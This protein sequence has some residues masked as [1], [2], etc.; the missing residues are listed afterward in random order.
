MIFYIISNRWRISELKT[1]W[2]SWVGRKGSTFLSAAF[3]LNPG[4]EAPGSVSYLT[5][6]EMLRRRNRLTSSCYRVYDLWIEQ[7][8]MEKLMQKKPKE[9]NHFLFKKNIGNLHFDTFSCW[10]S[11]CKAAISPEASSLMTAWANHTHIK[12]TWITYIGNERNLRQNLSNI[13]VNKQAL[14]QMI[15]RRESEDVQEHTLLRMNFARWANFSVLKVSAALLWTNTDGEHTI[16]KNTKIKM[17]QQICSVICAQSL[18]SGK[19]GVLGNG[20]WNY[21]FEGLTVAITVVLELPPR[22]SC[23]QNKYLKVRF[24]NSE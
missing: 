10:I 17:R 13:V 20:T 22:E 1:S 14:F 23:S 24:S 12:S 6:V 15:C 18:Y 7:M 9:S 2:K 16:W 8:W 5:I 11:R 21:L 19:D 4:F 3:V